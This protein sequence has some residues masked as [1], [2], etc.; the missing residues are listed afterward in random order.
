MIIKRIKEMMLEFLLIVAGTVICAA[1]FCTMFF[2]NARFSIS[3]L[4]QLL[5]FAFLCTLPGFIFC[6]KKELGKKQMRLRKIL[7]LFTL[8]SLLLFFGYYWGWLAAGSIIQPVV[9]ILLFSVSYIMV[10]YFTY[11][12]EKKVARML[13]ESLESYKKRTVK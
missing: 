3:L 4:W 13:N 2:P 12:R 6:S 10:W 5:T 8:I 7:H 9:I 1:V 11:L